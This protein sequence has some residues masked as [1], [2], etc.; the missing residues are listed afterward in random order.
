MN[1]MNKVVHFEIPADDMARAKKFYQDAF[2]WQMHDVPDM[3]YVIAL[4][5][6]STDGEMMRPKEPGAINGGMMERNENVKSPSLAIGVENID[7]VIEKVKRMGGAM[8]MEKTEVPKMGFM[9]YFKDTEG[10]VM[11][12]WQPVA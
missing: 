2:G 12:L 1:K 11:S 5:T 8:V 9:A 3:D 10:N 6:E 4:T 7:E